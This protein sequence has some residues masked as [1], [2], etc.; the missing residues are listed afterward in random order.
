M[1]KFIKENHVK[2]KERVKIRSKGGYRAYIG[3][4]RKITPSLVLFCYFIVNTF[5][6]L[7]F[8]HRDRILPDWKF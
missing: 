4:K 1:C 6:A 8:F 3:I 2:R 5:I 7:V